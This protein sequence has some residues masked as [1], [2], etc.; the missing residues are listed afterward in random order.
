MDGKA[1]KTSTGQRLDLW[2]VSGEVFIENPV[3]GG[4]L[5]GFIEKRNEMLANKT[6]SVFENLK[7]SHNDLLWM[8]STR[9][10]IGVLVLMFV[11]IGLLRFYW[12]KFSYDETRMYGA[13]G[14]TLVCGAMV[15]G[16]TD[17]F[18]SLKI[19]IGYFFILNAILIRLSEQELQS[20]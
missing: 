10:I 7:H 2:R 18:M 20:R 19:T 9:G 8:A 16:L 11:Y 5:Q 6:I 3:I 4:G 12:R 15:Y 14:L 17:I 1:G 13:A